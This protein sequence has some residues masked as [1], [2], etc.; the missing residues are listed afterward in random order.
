MVASF[1]PA[2]LRRRPAT[3][4]ATSA[5]AEA[6]AGSGTPGVAENPESGAVGRN[7]APDRDEISG[8]LP[9]MLVPHA[10]Q[11]TSGN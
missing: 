11:R 2:R 1:Q 9:E 3:S 5:T 7:N 4:H 6:D 8:Q 10:E